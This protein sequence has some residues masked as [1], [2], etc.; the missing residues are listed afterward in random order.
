[1]TTPPLPLSAVARQVDGNEQE[2]AGL[3]HSLDR[4]LEDS[5]AGRVIDAEV[6]LAKLRARRTG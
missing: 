4:A 6:V 2:H 1:M 3:D 5:K